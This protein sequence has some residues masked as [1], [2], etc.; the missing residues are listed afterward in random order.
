MTTATTPDLR[1]ELLAAAQ[2]CF[3]AVTAREDSAIRA[4]NAPTC[5]VVGP[6]GARLMNRDAVAE[7]VRNHEGEEEYEIDEDTVTVLPITDATGAIA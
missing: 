5:L 4:L 7:I 6:T 3:A 2:A 1:S